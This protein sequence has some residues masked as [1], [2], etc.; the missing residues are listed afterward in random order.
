[1]VERFFTEMD[2]RPE[3]RGMRA[4]HAG[5]LEPVK[6]ALKRYPGEWLGGP[7]LYSRDRGQ[8][9]LRMRHI[10]FP[11]GAA[12]RDAWLACMS[13]ALA[14]TVADAGLRE[15][16]YLAMAALADHMRNQDPR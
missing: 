13:A 2:T 8:P 12:Q 1:M 11:I 9:S 3:A 4:M 15:G 14:E 6:F 5:R 7:P 16:V 10:R